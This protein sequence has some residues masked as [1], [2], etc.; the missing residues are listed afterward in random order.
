MAWVGTPL[1]ALAAASGEIGLG[2]ATAFAGGALASLVGAQRRNWTLLAMACLLWIGLALGSLWGARQ[3]ADGHHVRVA[4]IQANVALRD[5][6][7]E[8][9]IDSTLAPHTLLTEKAAA[10][11]ALLAVWA[12]TAVPAYL[13][14]EPNLLEWVRGQARENA[15]WLYA[16]FPHYALGPRGAPRR[17]NSSGLFDP[18]GELRD[19][20]DKHHLLPFGERMPFQSLLPWLGQVDFGQAEWAA[21]APPEPMRVAYPGGA[22]QFSGLICF[23]AIFSSLARDA[24]RGG[25]DLLVNITND[26]WFGWTAGPRQHAAMARLRAAECGVPVVRCANNGISFV[27]DARGRLLAEAGLDERAVVAADIT[28]GARGT[29]FVRW[30]A[31][32]LAGLLACWAV[33]SLRPPQAV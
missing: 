7:H 14:H 4:A 21:G 6:W 29:P 19:R 18:Q 13:L 25:A 24:T 27:A 2:A 33:W 28:P 16:G 20:Y 15:L 31:W 30:G 10:D 23:E 3:G 12:E 11:G 9:R 32:P 22:F 26:G 8:S 1:R 17:T 5:K